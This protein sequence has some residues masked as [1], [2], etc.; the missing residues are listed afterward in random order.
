M[1]T[2][3]KAEKEVAKG[4]LWRAKE[5]L[6][7]AIPQAGYNFELFEKLGKVLLAM[8]NLP[9]AGRFLFLSGM[10]KPEYE[11]SIN[12]FLHKFRK[13]KPHDLLRG[14]P[15]KARLMTLSE[16]PV[17][18][19]QKLRELGFPEILKDKKGRVRLADKSGSDTVFF[20]TCLVIVLIVAGLVVMGIIKLKEII[21]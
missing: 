7:G 2:L 13:N 1:R 14:F 17:G 15:R 5:I 8:G 6:Q 20:V 10:R 16:Y 19:A 12:I 18:V 4:N 9:E 21:F 11:E 3:E